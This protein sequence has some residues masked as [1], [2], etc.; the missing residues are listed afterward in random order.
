MCFRKETTLGVCVH[1]M[2]CNNAMPQIEGR[3]KV[4]LT[5][6]QLSLDITYRSLYL[7]HFIRNPFDFLNTTHVV[8]KQDPFDP[9]ST[10][11]TPLFHQIVEHLNSTKDLLVWFFVKIW[12]T[13]NAQNN[14]IRVNYVRWTGFSQ[15]IIDPM[16]YLML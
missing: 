12:C 11:M 14:Y 13:H 8:N 2:L 15:N 6:K 5:S 7:Q 9:L 4:I 3:Q 16:L 10:N 1:F